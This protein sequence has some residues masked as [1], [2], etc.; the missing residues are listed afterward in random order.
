MDLTF[1][2]ISQL[3]EQAINQVVNPAD[4]KRSEFHYGRVHGILFAC[5]FLREQ[6]QTEME[7]QA[8]RQQQFEREF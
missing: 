4:D 3:R 7:A 1:A 6:I 5:E 2:L 8:Q